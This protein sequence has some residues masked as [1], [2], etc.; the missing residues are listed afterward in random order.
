[1]AMN[2]LLVILGQ[3]VMG[4]SENFCA[5]LTLLQSLHYMLTGCFVI[6]NMMC[7]FKDEAQVL[8]VYLSDIKSAC[9]RHSF[10]IECCDVEHYHMFTASRSPGVTLYHLGDI[11]MSTWVTSHDVH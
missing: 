7:Y 4:V 2:C 1:M 9:C 8:T 5:V 11:I 6:A 3:G 10:C